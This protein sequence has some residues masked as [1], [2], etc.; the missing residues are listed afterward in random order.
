[1]RFGATTIRAAYH[2]AAALQIL[3]IRDD[4]FLDFLPTDTARLL[5]VLQYGF[6]P[7]A[8]RVQLE[9]LPDYG[10]D[11]VEAVAGPRINVEKRGT[12]RG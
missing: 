5:N 11:W 7:Y 9:L 1:M 2:E 10:A 8:R 6:N 3:D 4:V 12:V